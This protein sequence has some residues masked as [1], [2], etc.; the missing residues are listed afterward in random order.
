VRDDFLKQTITE[1]AKGVGY[2]C[3][4]PEC[5]RPTVAANAEQTGVVTIGV[6]AHICAASP[7]GARYNSAQTREIRRSK[8]N[9][10][11]LCQN[12]G[13]LI[14][15]DPGKFT[16]ELLT[17][18]KRSAQERALRELVAPG[19]PLTEEAARIGSLAASDD[20]GAADAEFAARFQNVH[21][22]ATED[23][24]TYTRTALWGRT[25]VELTLKLLDEPDAPPF[26]ISRLPAALEVAPEI[27]LVAPPGTGKT[28]TVLQLARHVIAGNAIVPLYFR[29]GDVPDDNDGLLATLSQRTA[30]RGVRHDDL[31][32]LAQ[33]GRLLLVLDGWNELDAAAR[34][35]I[36]LDLDRIRLDWP[37]VRIVATTR[38]QV[39][40]VPIGGPRIAI[41]LLSENQQMSIAR[42]QSGDAGANIVDDAWRTGGVRQLIATPLYLSAL[43][44]GASRGARPTTKEEVLRLFVEQHERASEHAETLNAVLLGCH[45]SV[46]RALARHLN[47]AAST[48]MAESEARRVVVDALNELRQQGQMTGQPE[49]SAVLDVLTSHHVLTRSGSGGGTIS[50]QHQQFQEWFASYDVEDLM[51]RSAGAEAGAQVQLRATVLDQPAWEE[52]VLFAVERV[53]REKD[54]AVIVAHAI[55]LALAIDP[56]LAAEMIYR[57]GVG[58]WEAVSADVISFIG[59][60]HKPGKVDR[61]V[62]FMIM[63]GRPEFAPLIWPLAS[64][65]DSQIQLPTL[66]TAPRFRPSVLGPDLAPKVAALPDETREH[67]LALIASESGV[68]GMELATE[69]AKADPSPKVQSEVVQYLLFRRAD[70]HASALL[71]A[72]HD[73]TWALVASRGYADEVSDPAVAK[74]LAQERDKILTE[75][76]KPTERL[77]LLLNESASEPGR[78]EKI[79]AAIADPD[80]PVRD[81]QGDSSLYFAQKRAPAAVLQGLK[82]RI[83]DG[84]EL[85]FHADDFLDQLDVVDDGPI[86]AAILDTSRDKRG[87]NKLAIL[88]GPKTAGALIDKY[89][90][91]SEALRADRNNKQLGDEYHRAR[92]RVTTTRPSSFVEA[93]IARANT[94]DLALIYDLCDLVAAHGD[95]NDRSATIAVDAEAKSALIDI[96]RRWTE[97]VVTSP[98]AKRWH[99]N[100][101]SNAIG[102][103][104]LRE[105]VPELIRLL[106][107]ELA[108]LAKAR[109][110]FLEA[111]RRGDIQATSDASMRYGNQYQRAFSLI[112]GDDVARAVITYLEDPEF[113]FEAALVLKSV[114]DKHLKVPEPD[115]FRRWP[116]FDEVA[117]ARA[118]RTAAPIAEPANTYADPIWAAINRLANPESDKP[119]Q[120]LAIKLSRIAL[121]MPHR[122]QDALIARVIALPQPLTSKRE[123]LAAMAMDGQVIDAHLVMQAIDD[124]IADAGTD[125]N[126]AWHK[127]QN[128][129]EIEPWL[130]LLPYTDNPGSVI[131]GL[132]KVKAFYQAGWA[133]GWERVLTAVAVMPGPS[134]E[135]LLAKLAREHRDI[136][137]EFEWM[138]DI[139][140]RNTASAVLLYVDLFMENVFGHEV[141]GPDAW[142][143]GRELAQYVAK[144]PELKA[145]LK[146]RYETASGKARAMLEHLFGEIG[147]EEDLVAM[148]RK[149]AANGQRYDQRMDRAVYA[150]AVQ[151]IPVSEGSNSYNIHPAPVGTVRKTLFGMLDAKSGEAA[152]AKQCLSTIDHLRDEYGIAAN[153]PRHPDVMSGKPWPEESG[154]H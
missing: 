108:R 30:F 48:A 21:T 93:L 113:G 13:R 115:F 116:W 144:F 146:K 54:G 92:S 33:R 97:T 29:L 7:G 28:T 142:H 23:L 136:A 24:A 2:R 59:R 1:I 154:S 66:R 36:R 130:E 114:S 38:R 148:V 91:C 109:D 22:A 79:A 78:D 101:V 100:E 124:W 149:Y 43:L 32:A 84:L 138:K 107:G 126:K 27:T 41:E 6:A 117:A 94:D 133:K 64:S 99:L 147:D 67:L 58:I 134:G 72:A 40:D 25:Q 16:V 11:W 80:F 152:L 153:D 123:L 120:E 137:T 83:E 46:L 51:R 52:S 57:S 17:G 143:L 105:L 55:R 127:R 74:R 63:T 61:P 45:A 5:A 103:F 75:A 106:D 102:R 56:M 71:A 98:E 87:D 140:R 135:A 125:T 90:A 119:R 128:T 50:F 139:L 47:G 110:G 49:P 112:A 141:H 8:E 95:T 145:E 129:W 76:K 35:R 9:G 42:A 81:Q 86:A 53:S 15:A 131:E 19:L 85:P 14:D 150:V 82:R 10:I 12:C 4:N 20:A 132:A 121:A 77:R 122:N 104:G 31:V 70:R 73:E 26:S 151:E 68:D 69:L 118:A 65:T 88:A 34:K 62:R 3:S 60:W 37:H 44:G 18:W 111:R 89:L 96:L 39:L